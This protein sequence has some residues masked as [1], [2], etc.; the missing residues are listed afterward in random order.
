MGTAVGGSERERENRL[1]PEF[2]L[3]GVADFWG[4][5]KTGVLEE[6]WA[7][8]VPLEVE[9]LNGTGAV[10]FT[11]SKLLDVDSVMNLR[12]KPLL[13]LIVF[14]FT[15]FVKLVSYT[16]LIGGSTE[17]PGALDCTIWKCLPP[18]LASLSLFSDS[19][20]L[21]NNS[22]SMEVTSRGYCTAEVETGPQKGPP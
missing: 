11:F 12:H 18:V 17:A 1:L 16:G 8:F 7:C 22:A 10:P 19:S 4:E 13:S 2:P 21:R 20:S 3:R 5:V 6:F 9:A 15:C 14:K